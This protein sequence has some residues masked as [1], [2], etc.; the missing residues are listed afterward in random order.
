MPERLNWHRSANGCCIHNRCMHIWVCICVFCCISVAMMCPNSHPYILIF[1]NPLGLKLSMGFPFWPRHS[2]AILSISSHEVFLQPKWK[3]WSL[4][5]STNSSA[6]PVYLSFPSLSIMWPFFPSFLL[7][8]AV[9]LHNNP[10]PAATASHQHKTATL[11][12]HTWWIILPDEEISRYWWLNMI[13]FTLAH[14]K[15]NMWR[16]VNQT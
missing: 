7:S 6:S 13:S 3:L 14:T 1:C 12:R 2:V 8:V 10:V 16:E 15:E 4:L 9:C 5:Q 11:L